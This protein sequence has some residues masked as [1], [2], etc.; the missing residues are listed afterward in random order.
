[1]PVVEWE[2]K[3][4]KELETREMAL[5]YEKSIKEEVEWAVSFFVV[6]PPGAS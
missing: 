2:G 6:V 3:A 1:M 4:E 5:E